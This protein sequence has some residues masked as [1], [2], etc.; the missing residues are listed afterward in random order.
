[1]AAMRL[2]QYKAERNVLWRMRDRCLNPK[3]RSYR[4]YGAR[5]IRV[6]ERWCGRD[7]F[8]HFLAD[9]GPRP[10]ALYSIE[11]LD[12]NGDYEPSN[13]RW[14]TALVQ[15]HNKQRSGAAI[16][17]KWRQITRRV[18]KAPPSPT[19][20]ARRRRIEA[21][22]VAMERKAGRYTPE[23]SSEHWPLK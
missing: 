9:M 14:A 22:R 19:I 7:G 3:N 13:V 1:M 4:W 6:C 15:A 16:V 2:T 10:S 20:E 18:V 11:R 8:R 12:V 5:G 17:E 21:R 23:R